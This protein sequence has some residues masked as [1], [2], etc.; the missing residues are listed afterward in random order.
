[1]RT[2]DD[3]IIQLFSCSG[4][5]C[6]ATARADLVALSVKVSGAVVSSIGSSAN[7][8]L[9]SFI[10]PGNPFAGFMTTTS[11]DTSTTTNN[12][13]TTPAPVVLPTIVGGASGSVSSVAE[14][15]RYA[16]NGN[17]NVL[18]VNGDLTVLCPVGRSVFEMEGV[19]TVIV[20][21]D[22]I[23]RCNIIYT[24]S[25]TTSSWAWITKGGNIK[26]SNGLGTLSAG[27]ITNMAGVFVSVKD[28]TTGGDITYI[29]NA[30]TQA[31][32]R[33]E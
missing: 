9:Q 23:I 4:T 19:R 6:S 16:V 14:I 29:D 25:D 33:V 13:V 27:A 12:A 31:I 24:S 22:L 2:G 11:G 18:A 20:T 32:L 30:T 26:V 3:A 21:G 28:G 7:R 5:D 8:S 1:M 10:N 17:K 15:E